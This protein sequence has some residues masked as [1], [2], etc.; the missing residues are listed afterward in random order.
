MAYLIFALVFWPSAAGAAPI[1]ALLVSVGAGAALAGALTNVVIA[2][3][4]NALASVFVK[5]PGQNTP[6]APSVADA[7]VNVRLETADR[8]QLG[9]TIAAGGAVGVFAEFDN[10][11]RLWY[12]V[13][14]GDA[15]LTGNPSYLLDD[16]PVTLSDGT[17]GFTAGDVLTNE[18]CLEDG[19]WSQYEGTGT[20]YPVYRIYTVTPDANDAYGALPSAFTSA[21]T[22]LPADFRL[23]GVCYT[24]VRCKSVKPEH[25]YTAFHW[26]GAL[27][28]GEPSVVL[29]GNFGRMYDPRE[30]GHDV[31][32]QSTWTATDGNAAIVAANFRIA[33]YG[34]NRPVTEVA[35]DQVAIQADICDQTVLDLNGVSTPLYRAAYAFPDSKPRS[36][37]ER[38]ILAAADA[39]SCYDDAG[40]W[41]PKV[42]YYAAPTL[43]ISANR[44]VLSMQTQITDDGETAVD[45]VVVYYLDPSLN[46]TRQP[47]A[48]WTNPEWFDAA[49][50]PNYHYDD[51]LT[52]T[53][54]NQAVRLA[55]AIGLR[56]AAAKRA[57]LITTIKGVLATN[58]RAVDLDIDSDFSGPFEIVSRVEQDPSGMACSFAVVPMPT[59]KWYLNPGEEGEPPVATPALG[60]T[61]TDPNLPSAL[62]SVATSGGAGTATIYFT[63]ANDF[64]QF[65]VTIWRGA[66]TTFSAAT[67][68][69]TV[70]VL[71]NVSTF[72]TE[73]G[74]SAGTYYYWVRPQ[75][76]AANAGP[77]SGPYTVTVT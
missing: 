62:T 73:T 45:G 6:K 74:L 59:D 42:G 29:V 39:I 14:H 68:V 51:I 12:I 48:P 70:A 36:E 41:Y 7:R 33:K 31:N 38:E 19:V 46:Y 47:C 17:D 11:G 27:G 16:I 4:V 54:H 26:R 76:R 67:L 50:I 30:P 49:A 3:A 37:C 57:S 34:R 71:A 20:K 25:R 32:D 5:K 52:C 18:F 21:F 61:K 64:N 40:K 10:S 35:W 75:N 23:A 8:W 2:V 55:K 66:T 9:G 63:T 24:I 22:S 13:A 53:S 60:L 56:I 77:T 15:E 1:T 43:E 65:S 28:L 58:E 44:D 69:E 72:Y